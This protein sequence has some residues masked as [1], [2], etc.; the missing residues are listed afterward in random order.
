LR[1]LPPTPPA[2]KT[3]PRRQ[4][5]DSIPASEAT[6]FAGTGQLRNVAHG[7]LPLQGHGSA[8]AKCVD[9]A[10]LQARE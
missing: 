3:V 9:G 4:E 5:I 10:L 2:E 8:R 6:A 1:H 7:A